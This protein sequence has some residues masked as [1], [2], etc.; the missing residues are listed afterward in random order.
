MINVFGIS[1][2]NLSYSVARVREIASGFSKKLKSILNTIIVGVILVIFTFDTGISSYN[3][4]PSATAYSNQKL[5]NGT[6]IL[7]TIEVSTFPPESL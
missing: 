1:I 6:L 3:A 5:T 4:S 2:T 7:S